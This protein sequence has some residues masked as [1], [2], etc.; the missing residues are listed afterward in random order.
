MGVTRCG[1]WA[2]AS[3]PSREPARRIAIIKR[4]SGRD[5]AGRPAIPRDRDGRRR[6][7]S[8]S[9]RGETAP[10]R[11]MACFPTHVIPSAPRG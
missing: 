1:V 11:L 3:P 5:G 6:S 2:T 9:F 10:S 8:S 7:F 4:P